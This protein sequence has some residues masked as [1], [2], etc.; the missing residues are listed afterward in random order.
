[1]LDNSRQ[2]EWK[3]WMDFDAGVIVQGDVV[4]ELLD[5]GVQMLPTQWMETDQNEHLKRP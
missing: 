5:D 1:M 2:K 3:K 4:K